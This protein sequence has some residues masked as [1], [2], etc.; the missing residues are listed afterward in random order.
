MESIKKT[1]AKISGVFFLALLM[2]GVVYAASFSQPSR[3]FPNHNV[4]P[5]IDESN[6]NQVKNGD[7]NAKKLIGYNLRAD[8]VCLNG[9][10]RTSWP[11]AGGSSLNTTCT[12]SSMFNDVRPHTNRFPRSQSGTDLGGRCANYLSFSERND[13]WMP[14]AFDDCSGV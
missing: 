3:N 10:C 6:T 5:P 7:I 11:V 4:Y 8:E 13:G 14:V 1:T 12:T 9:D 2:G